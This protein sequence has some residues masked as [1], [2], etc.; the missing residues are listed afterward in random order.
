MISVN[1]LRL[2]REESTKR[3]HAILEDTKT[4]KE[5]NKS[6]QGSDHNCNNITTNNTVWC[7]NS[8]HILSN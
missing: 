3:T 7:C 8:V 6:R 4:N 1:L 2:M 5:E